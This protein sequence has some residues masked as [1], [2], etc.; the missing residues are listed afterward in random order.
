[1]TRSLD[2]THHL[3]S[4]DGCRGDVVSVLPIEESYVMRFAEDLPHAPLPP[5]WVMVV[6]PS[7]DE[8]SYFVNQSRQANKRAPYV[9]T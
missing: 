7:E 2:L 8:C 3:R 6:P 4:R 9:R 5:G 1:M